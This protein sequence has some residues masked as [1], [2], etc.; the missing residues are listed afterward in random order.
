MEACQLLGFDKKLVSRFVST[1]HAAGPVI[2]A[3]GRF[4]LQPPSLPEADAR[5]AKTTLQ[6]A[7]DA[8]VS[9]S[10]TCQQ[11]ITRITE[12]IGAIERG[13]AAANARLQAAMDL[14]KPQHDYYKY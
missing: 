1:V 2:L 3:N 5:E 8:G 9:L 7:V 10:D 4:V 11:Q 6:S 14:L 13:E 12:E